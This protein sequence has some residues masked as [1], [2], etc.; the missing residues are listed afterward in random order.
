VDLPRDLHPLFWD[1]RPEA[2]DPQA[3]APFVLERVLE[4]GSLAGARWALRTYGIE[5]IT[6]FLRTRGV[7]TLSRKTLSF[8]TVLLGLE[9][10]ACFQRSSLDRSRPFWN[11]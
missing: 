3:H 4:Y 2:V 7:R 8:W 6:S 11:Y 10:E 9:G 5:R 1:C